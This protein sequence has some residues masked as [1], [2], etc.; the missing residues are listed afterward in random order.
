MRCVTTIV[1]PEPHDVLEEHLVGIVDFVRAAEPGSYERL[2]PRSE[3]ASDGAHVKPP[4]LGV[5][6]LAQDLGV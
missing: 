4:S 2:I 3:A 6:S 1:L 5:G